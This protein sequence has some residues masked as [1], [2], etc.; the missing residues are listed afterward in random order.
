MEEQERLDIGG[1]VSWGGWKSILKEE[2]NTFLSLLWGGRGILPLSLAMGKKQGFGVV[3]FFF[4]LLLYKRK[5]FL[6]RQ[7]FSLKF[8]FL[9]LCKGGYLYKRSVSQEAKDHHPIWSKM[10]SAVAT[11]FTDA[12]SLLAE[13]F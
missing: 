5:D 1:G 12:V 2:R 7:F 4:V 13:I 6:S 3:V 8:G 9:L 10:V 11:P